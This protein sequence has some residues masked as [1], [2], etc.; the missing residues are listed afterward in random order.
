MIHLHHW[1]VPKWMREVVELSR[2]EAERNLPDRHRPYKPWGR[3]VMVVAIVSGLLGAMT[4]WSATPGRRQSPLLDAND[5]WLGLVFVVVGLALGFFAMRF[6]RLRSSD[7]DPP[8]EPIH[9]N[10]V[11]RSG[12]RG[13]SASRKVRAPRRKGG[14]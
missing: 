7:V 8:L 10:P 14:G 3:V 6:G 1:F 2:A 4:V 12:G 13:V 9:L 5:A 11:R